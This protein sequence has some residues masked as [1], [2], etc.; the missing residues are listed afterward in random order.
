MHPLKT[1][2]N[3]LNIFKQLSEILTSLPAAPNGHWQWSSTGSKSSVY[4]V[5]L[6]LLWQELAGSATSLAYHSHSIHIQYQTSSSWYIIWSFWF[7]HVD[8][9][10]I[11]IYIYMAVSQNC[12]WNVP[13][14][15]GRMERRGF[16]TVLVPGL[17]SVMKYK[18]YIN[19]YIYIYLL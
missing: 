12:V 6:M 1:I 7:V 14:C 2:L 10:I 18:L 17:W 8:T 3:F 11:Y 16:V 15:S 5:T 4:A 19:M 13:R 9:Y